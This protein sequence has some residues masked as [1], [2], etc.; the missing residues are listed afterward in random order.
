MLG[1]VVAMAIYRIVTF[2]I[3][4]HLTLVDLR[5]ALVMGLY[6]LTRVI[7]LM[8]LATILWVPIGVMIGLRPV[9][10]KRVGAAAQFLAAFP[11]NLLFPIFV[12]FIIRY[13][14]NPDIW[15]TPLI[16]LGAQF[17]IL[18]NVIAGANAFPGDLREAARNFRVGGLLWWRRVILPGIFPYFVT[19][20]ITASGGAWNAAV[21][22]EVVSW[23]HTTLK[24]HG[25]GAYIQE[26]MIAG[27]S[28]RVLLGMVVMAAFVLSFNR[29]VWRPMY[30]YSSRRLRL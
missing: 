17:Y 10:A 4:S 11:A 26:A 7:V 21:I 8:M 24:A 13:S 12:V 23:G 19:G 27:D 14:L 25:L 9:L 3:A 28:A 29:L 1:L 20:A 16:I 5:T 2:C 22:A 18:F 30:A 15:L 6:T